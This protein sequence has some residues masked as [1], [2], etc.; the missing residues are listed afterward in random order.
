MLGGRRIVVVAGTAEVHGHP[1]DLG[2]SIAV[3]GLGCRF[4]GAASPEELWH[5]V[6]NDVCSIAPL[7]ASRFNKPRYYDPAIGTYGK[8]YSAVGGWIEDHPF[9]A[10]H[11]RLTPRAIE[12]TDIAHLWTLEVAERALED[13]R[14]APDSIQGKNVAVIIGHARGSMMTANMAFATAVEGMLDGVDLVSAAV[15][16][17]TIEMLHARYPQ[18]NEDGGTGSMASGCAALIAHSFGLTGRHMVVD[19]A[20]ASSFAAIE[21]AMRGLE[22]GKIDLAIAGGASYSQEL[23][24]IMFAQSRALSPDGSFPFDR[25][26]NG[27][28]SSDGIGLFL[29][30]RMEDAMRDGD[31]VR[32]VLRGIGGSCDGKGRALWAPRKEGQVLAIR[33]A[34]REAGIDPAS[35]D[36]I[37]AHA[38]S[39]PL[40]DRVEVEALHEVFSASKRAAPLSIGSVKGNF[41]HTREAAGAAGLMK[42]ILALE[43]ATLPPTGNFREP[44]PEI[45]WRDVDIEVVT[46]PRPWNTRG[47]RRAGVD[48]F[49]IGGLN[50]HLLVEEAKPSP[51]LSIRVPSRVEKKPRDIAIVGI[52][53]RFPGAGSPQ[54]FWEVLAA[55]RDVMREA[56]ANRWNKEIYFQPGDR[57]PYRTYAKRG[58]YITDFVADWKR[59]KIPPKLIERNDPLQF[60]LLESAIDAIDDAKIDLQKIDRTR[61]GVL[62]GSVFGSDYALELA[63]AIRSTEVAEAV[64]EAMGLPASSE[65]I[66]AILAAIRARLPNINED[67]SGSFSSS[68]LASRTSKTLDLMGPSYSIDAACASSLASLEAAAELLGSGEVDVVLYGGG[69]RAMRVQRY[70]AYCQFYA[71]SR[72]DRPRPFDEA[73]DGF[74]PGEGAAVCVLK[75]LEDARRDGDHV[76]AVVKGIGSSSDGE[77]K[78]MHR[79]SPHGLARAMNRALDE[80]GLEV[81]SVGF[82]ECHGAGTAV[83]DRAEVA[84]LHEVYRTA[85]RTEPLWIGGVK[86]TVGH[87]QGAAGAIAV[88]KAAMALDRGLIPPTL[89]FERAHPDHQLGNTL[90]VAERVEVFPAHRTK[91]GRVFRA[92]GVS[93]MGLAG[94]NYHAV[95]MKEL[96]ETKPQ[97]PEVTPEMLALFEGETARAL[98]ATPGFAEF[99]DRTR[100]SVEELVAGLW[101][102]RAG[103]VRADAIVVSALPASADPVSVAP[104]AAPAIVVPRVERAE[105]REFV[106][107]ALANETGY[108]KDL[109]DPAADLEADLGID[110]VKQAQVLGKVRDKFNIRTDEKLALRDFPTINHVLDYVE[111]QLALLA[112][113]AV[114]SPATAR[115]AVPSIDLTARRSRLPQPAIA[116]PSV[117]VPVPLPVPSTIPV[118]SA[119]PARS[120]IPVPSITAVPSTRPARSEAS[121]VQVLHLRGT[122]REIGQQHGEAMREQIRE[123]MARY[124]DFLGVRG[125]EL[126]SLPST[127]TTVQ[128]LFDEASS[129]EIA[130]IAEAVGIPFRHV[131]AY[132]LDAALFPAYVSGCTQAV[133]LARANQGLLLHFV[134]EDSPLLL[135]LGGYYP[136]V[137]QVRRRTDAPDPKRRTVLFTVA[138]QSAGPNAVADNG[139]TVTSTTL[140]DGPPP[141]VIPDGVPHPQLVKRIVEEARTLEDANAIARSFRR[142]GR[143]SLLVSEASSD[144]ATYLEYDGGRVL[145]EEAISGARVTSNHALS[146]PADGCEVPEHSRHRE[147]RAGDLINRT[148]QLTVDDAKRTLRDREDLGRGRGVAHATMNTVRRVDNVMSLVVEPQSKRIH[149]TDRVVPAGGDTDAVQFFSLSYGS[150]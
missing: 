142:A 134:N 18:R 58:G 28:I 20:C 61:V 127:L 36:L 21:I 53:G 23:S 102:A 60:M 55:K 63:L 135:H 124:D 30:K 7:P 126:L 115:V 37:E 144:R 66:Q 22:Q 72:G 65:Q 4:P 77:R 133:R 78:S 109:I 3:I 143:W 70:E 45:P 31:R 117:P 128:S 67:S 100:G 121:P 27:F 149:V 51:G 8:S 136:R 6:S 132:N 92:A 116:T 129:E 26:A 64:S 79:N 9:S 25:R 130:G 137:I 99:W 101:R 15:K 57:A 93:S 34:Y 50:Y 56:P 5:N 10:K 2:K 110:T 83:G 98:L 29:L 59:H 112:Q 62:V 145:R 106:V 85:E 71:L 105:V 91:D 68:T 131:L 82:V 108:P 125:R 54:D 32:A 138:G 69:E 104:V 94:I 146:G 88:V 148:G 12:A 119:I 49:G 13:A 120:A 95:L 33:R 35:V 87:A 38:T 14:I 43:H 73:A 47:V 86:S 76:Y 52:G 90:R 41:G 39:T 150:V 111:K 44:S 46:A 42:A 123:V 74:L 97:S 84:A 11:A 81:S 96:E 139:L 80:S 75:R 118:P 141:A 16:A 140:L 107:S 147:A 89:G 122:A 113:K 114:A 17:R 48:A 19:A 1:M 103:D 24:V 40:G